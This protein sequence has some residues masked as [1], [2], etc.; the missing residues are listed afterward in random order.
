ML[1]LDSG[2]KLGLAIVEASHELEAQSAGD[3]HGC[4]ERTAIVRAAGY[5]LLEPEQPGRPWP[6]LLQEL[7]LQRDLRGVP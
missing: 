1:L 4:V 5:A 6:E 2:T 7:A 3:V